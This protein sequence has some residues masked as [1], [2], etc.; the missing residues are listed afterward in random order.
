MKDPTVS[1]STVPL[2]LDDEDP[3][4]Q[5]MDRPEGEGASSSSPSPSSES[6]PPPSTSTAAGGGD[7]AGGWSSLSSA[8]A[9]G[10]A[11]GGLALALALGLAFVADG[12]GGGG[13][14]SST[15][16]AGA[17]AARAALRARVL[18]LGG[19]P[20]P[21]D[22]PVVPLP[23][24]FAPLAA[25]PFGD[26]GDFPLGEAEAARG[27]FDRGRPTF[28]LGF[29]AVTDGGGGGEGSA[30]GAGA[31]TG[32]TSSSS[33]EGSVFIAGLASS[34][35][36]VPANSGERGGEGSRSGDPN[37]GLAGS[38]EE[39]LLA[40]GEWS[41]WT[42]EGGGYAGDSEG[43]LGVGVGD[44]PPAGEG[45]RRRGEDSD[46]GELD[47]RR[48][49]G[50]GVFGIGE[51]DLG[52]REGD[53][54]WGGGVTP[55]LPRGGELCGE[56]NVK[57]LCRGE[58]LRTGDLPRLASAGGGLRGGGLR[59]LSPTGELFLD[60]TGGGGVPGRGEAGWRVG[61]VF[62]GSALMN[63]VDLDTLDVRFFFWGPFPS[64][65]PLRMTLK[66]AREKFSA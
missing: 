44:L 42:G 66:V 47:R 3:A 30:A 24:A 53:G 21:G 13:A 32:F 10:G 48:R 8:G 40:A 39:R 5:A 65:A 49:W 22:F 58:D 59:G 57:A 14:S 11:A 60:R 54:V 36:G 61:G 27:D 18:A 41:E 28:P 4:L 38:G 34:V 6:P 50:D 29:G 33:G 63:G 1:A 7:R 43:V 23:P 12:G 25:F 16:A 9:G 31:V 64:D 56:V 62:R 20:R 15:V 45:E 55:T 37:S 19:R 35:G 51:G 52:A 2:C 17:A 46:W 26:L